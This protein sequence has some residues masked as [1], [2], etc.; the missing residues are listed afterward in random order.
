MLRSTLSLLGCL[1]P[2]SV[3]LYAQTAPPKTYIPLQ[4][5][6][7]LHSTPAKTSGIKQVKATRSSSALTRVRPG[8]GL[9]PVSHSKGMTL[10]VTPAFARADS[11]PHFSHSAINAVVAKGAKAGV[12]TAA[13]QPSFEHDVLPVIQKYCTECH[14]AEDPPADI[15]LVKYHD[16]N[17]VLQDHSIWE[18]VAAN[19]ESGHMPPKKMPQPS[20]QER[21]RLVQWV[22]STLS[23]SQCVLDP[24]RVTLHRLNRVE[25]NNTIRDLVGV[26]FHP[27]DDFPSDDVGYGFD[28]IGDVLSISPLL[29]EKYFNAA[30]QVAEKAIVLPAFKTVH[31]A[32]DHLPDDAG[33]DFEGTGGR[34]LGTEVGEVYIEYKFP[35]DGEYELRAQAF[36]QQAGPDPARM[37]FR[38]DGKPLQT[39][40]VTALQDSPKVYPQR[41]TVKAGTHRLAVAFTNNYKNLTTNDPKLRG[42]RNLIIQYLEVAGPFNAKQTLPASHQRIIFCRTNEAVRQQAAHAIL[43]AFASR[44]YRRPVTEAEVERLLRYVN[45]AQKEG[46]PFERGIQ[47]AVEAVLTSPNFLFRVELDPHPNDPKA[48]RLL[49]SYELAS[50]LS[51]FLWNSMPDDELFAVAGSGDLQNKDVLAAQVKRMLKDPRAQVMADNFAG[52]WLQLRRLSDMTPDPEHFPDF[53]EDLRTAMRRETELFFEGV[54][55]QDRSVLDFIDA[56]YTYVNATLAKHYGIPDITGP[57]FRRVVLTGDLAAQR[58]GVLTQAS[59]LTV[60]SNPTRTS[61]VKRGKWVLEQIL[62]AAPPPPPPNLPPLKEDKEAVNAA[63]I[64]ERMAQHRKDPACASCHAQMDPIGFG[65]E[66]YDPVGA[67]R[68]MDGRFPV[69]ASGTLTDGSTFQGPA[70]LKTILKSKKEVF[71]RC[72]TEKMLTYALGRGLESYDRCIVDDIVKKVAKNNYR[73]SALITAVVESDPFRKRRGDEG[74]L[75]NGGGASVVKVSSNQSSAADLL[76]TAQPDNHQAAPKAGGIKQ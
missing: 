29:M 34:I 64:R 48:S 73:F 2:C 13:N 53:N 28:N 68:K 20:A 58:G 69:D 1:V 7:S 70:Q 63:T 25:Y 33:A 71:V 18:K 62:N 45:M 15:A 23:K 46:E 19:V 74:L 61:P 60:T 42:D 24:G 49:N 65:L 31:F 44:A 52:Q 38:L 35:L 22:E 66:N 36:Q 50:R 43:S 32:P 5:A 57:D 27:A 51:Y 72:L 59:V 30:E 39:V 37:V 40:D 9:L 56:N 21:T 76:K 8:R 10:P 67:W 4:S 11:N 47:L 6:P 14:S 55:Q 26:D 75:Q 3:V 17:S 16:V 41:I 12:K 54:A